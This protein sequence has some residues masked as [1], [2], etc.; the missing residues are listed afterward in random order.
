E[1]DRIFPE[2]V[3]GELTRWGNGLGIGVAEQI[4]T[5]GK[6]SWRPRLKIWHPQFL[7]WD[8]GSY[9]YKILTG[10]GE[11]ELPRIDENPNGDG[12]WVVWCPYGYQYSW[13]R[14]LLRAL[15]PKYIMR[16]WTYRDWARYNELHGQGIVKA[17]APISALEEEKDNYLANVANRGAEPTILVEQGNDG[18]KYDIDL[19]EPKG[20]TWDSFEHHKQALDTDIAILWLGQNLTT[21][22]PANGSSSK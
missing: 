16:G 4:Y 18:N 22:S 13:L 19:V 3:T 21:E 15:A 8:W 7:R 5:T 17:I 10:E 20:Q 6:D 9:S 1:W 12:R 11:V 14:G 2:S